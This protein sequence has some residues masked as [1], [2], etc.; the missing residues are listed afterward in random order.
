MRID[1]TAGGIVCDVQGR[2]ILV[3]QPGGWVL[4]KGHIETGE[5]AAQA[6]VREVQEETGLDVKIVEY[7][8]Q[9][10]RKSSDPDYQDVVKEI[11][12]FL[13]THRG[14]IPNMVPEEEHAWIP[15]D[16]ALRGMQYAEESAFLH[17]HQQKIAAF[18]QRLKP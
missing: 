11:K 12:L 2:L 5:T 17:V 7:L 8:G 16:E 4:P 10:T 3:K 6:A 14:V 9:V 13:M 1:F 15:W 18:Y